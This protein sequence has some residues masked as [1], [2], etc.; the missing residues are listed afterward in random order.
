MLKFSSHKFV[1]FDFDGVL[2]D[3]EI[4]AIAELRECISDFGVKL[5]LEETQERFLGN[6]IGS[7]IAF[8]KERTGQDCSKTLQPNWHSRLFQR[9]ENE[10]RVMP[11]AE[12][13][14]SELDRLQISYCIASGG[15]IARVEFALNL[16]ELKTRFVDRAF[17]AELVNKG[18]PDPALFLYAAEQCGYSPSECVVIEDA[19][20]G[21]LAAKRAGMSVVGFMGGSHLT[22]SR[23]KYA[24]LLTQNGAE[25]IF[26]DFQSI[27]AEFSE[28]RAG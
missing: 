21:V 5:S 16:T 13:L 10:L 22:A 17:S 4:I 19:P 23:T 2:I 6:S 14:L 11:G 12:E 1:I 7:P 24:D 20:A 27:I 25:Q 15:S 9:Y 3:S 26:Y 18:K 8:I 28:R